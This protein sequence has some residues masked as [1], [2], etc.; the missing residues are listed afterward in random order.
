M[1]ETREHADATQGEALIRSRSNNGFIDTG[2]SHATANHPL[3]SEK[4]EEGFSLL[5][6]SILRR[7]A[8]FHQANDLVNRP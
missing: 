8:S 6:L 7:D 2:L 5:H 1:F 4:C 3:V